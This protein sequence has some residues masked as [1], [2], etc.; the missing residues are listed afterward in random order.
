MAG[1][2]TATEAAAIA[3]MYTFV[4]AFFIKKSR[5]L[6]DYIQVIRRAVI[7]SASIYILI[8]AAAILSWVLSYYQELYPAVNYLIENDFSPT[9]F[10]LI[11]ML[12]C[13]VLLKF[14]EPKS[15][16]LIIVPLSVSIIR[17]LRIDP[18]DAGMVTVM[19]TRLGTVT[20]AYGLSALLASKIDGTK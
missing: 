14:R 17:V 8:G 7:D 18:I 15:A 12:I 16:M 9:V 2:F 3:V 6:S 19:S 4:V 20:P 10:L 1:I 13:V 11:F 5:N